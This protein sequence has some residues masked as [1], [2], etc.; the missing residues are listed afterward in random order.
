MTEFNKTESYKNTILPLLEQIEQ[1]CK[2][3]KLPFFFTIA[4]A[5]DKKGTKYESTA[6]TPV[7]M[8][9][10]LAEDKIVKHINVVNGFDTI[11]PEMIPE[12]E[13]DIDDSHNQVE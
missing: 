6:L 11:P 1:L 13:F 3:E 5:N 2:M 12:L 4:I 7:P 10:M 8:E 9:L